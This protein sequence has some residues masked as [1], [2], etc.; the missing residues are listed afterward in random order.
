MWGVQRGVAKV[1]SVVNY[2]RNNVVDVL[3]NAERAIEYFVADL[4]EPI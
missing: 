4:I 1:F 2:E 3:N